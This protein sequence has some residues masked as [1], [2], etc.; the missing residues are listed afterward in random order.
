M[1]SLEN[2]LS[3]D[4]NVLGVRVRNYSECGYCLDT[5]NKV[6]LSVPWAIW[7]QWQYISTRMGDKEW[8]GIF[9]VKDDSVSGFK[10][11]KQEVTKVECEF[12]EEL[13]GDGIVHSHHDMG[14]F[15]SSQD[16]RHARN[17]YTYSIVVSNKDGYE[18][19]KRIKLPCGGFG[20]LKVEIR[21]T[22]LPKIDLTKISE[23][24]EYMPDIHREGERQQ[25]FLRD[26]PSCEGCVTQDCGSCPLFDMG[27]LPCDTCES[28]K[29]KTCKLPIPKD[30]GE[31]LPFCNYCEEGSCTSCVRLDAYLKNYPEDKELLVSKKY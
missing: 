20:Y 18:A 24:S 23:R 14:A 28:F 19:T 11:P 16:D 22:E 25:D 15:H 8:G 29:C 27:L 2:S 21:L 7:S 3:K 6:V 5:D 9:W 13:G 31:I 4:S 10:I 12:K 17:L 30:M 1:L 26:T